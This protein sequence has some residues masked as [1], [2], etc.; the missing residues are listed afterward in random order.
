[1]E[2]AIKPVEKKSVAPVDSSEDKPSACPSRYSWARLLARIYEVFHLLCPVCQQE[3]KI[4]SFITEADVIVK[5]LTA[6]DEEPEAPIVAP[7]RAP[8]LWEL[9][10]SD[11]SVDDEVSVDSIPGDHFDQSVSW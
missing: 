7:A 11:Q 3:M 10:D 1:M 4:I 2:K 9:A 8:P 5:L 6:M